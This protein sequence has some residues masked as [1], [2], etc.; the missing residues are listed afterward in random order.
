MD[1][2]SFGGDEDILE[3]D[4]GDMHN[5]VNVSNVT[6]NAY[7]KTVKMVNFLLGIFYHDKKK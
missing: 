6:L 3:M 4:G 1:T 2:V 5:N 7:L